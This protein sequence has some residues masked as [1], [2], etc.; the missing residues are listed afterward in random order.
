MGTAT[1]GKC[2]SSLYPHEVLLMMTT[3]T[4]VA[5]LRRQIWIEQTE[6]AGN[7]LIARYRSRGPLWEITTFDFMSCLIVT[8]NSTLPL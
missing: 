4:K 8:A 7:H 1:N 6:L 5:I 2:I 3:L